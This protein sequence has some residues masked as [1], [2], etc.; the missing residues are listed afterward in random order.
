MLDQIL[1]HFPPH[2]HPLSLVHDPDGLLADEGV[3]A[4][5]AEQGFTLLNEADPVALRHRVQQ[6]RPF[7]LERPLILVTA[8]PLN[9]LPYDLWQPGHPVRLALHTFFPNLS[10]PVV[11]C[12]SPHQRWRLSQVPP[13]QRKLG[14]GATIEAILAGVFGVDLAALRQP[15]GL[16]AWLNAYHPQ[17]DPM[18][19][20]LIER[21]LAHLRSLPVYADWPL[22]DLLTSQDAFTRFVEDQWLTYLQGQTGQPLAE[23]G[24]RYLFYGD[25]G[26]LSFETD[27][28][29]QDTLPQLVRSGA[30]APVSV[31]HPERLPAWMRVGVLAPE[32]DHR[33]RRM[34]ELL[35]VLAE[36]TAPLDELARARWEQWQAV[37]RAWGELATLYYDPDVDVDVG[38]VANLP[39]PGQV[40]N[41]PGQASNLPGQVGNLPGQVSNLP[42]QV[43]NLS[44]SY[45]WWQEKLDQAFLAWLQ[46]RYTPLGGRKLPTPHHL[47]HVLPYIAY[48]WCQQGSRERLALLIMDGMSLADWHLIKSTWRA[49]HPSW[50]FQEQLV[51]AQIPP[52]TAISR[53]ALVSG[54]RSADFSDTLTHNRAE[55][56]QW[57][58]FWTR[59]GLPRSACAYSHL[60]LDRHEPPPELDSARIQAICLVVNVIDDMLHKASL[61]GADMQASLKLWL[62]RKS[63]RLEE[64]IDGLLGRG[65]TIYLTSDHGHTEARGM[66]LRSEGL[67]VETRSK[68]VRVYRDKRTAQNA[69]QGFSKT[70]LWGEDGLLPADTWALMPGGREAFAPFNETVVT[71]GG[72]TLD[73]VVVPLVQVTGPVRPVNDEA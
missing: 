41:L 8:G 28:A 72:P 53:Q 15:A 4:A 57:V 63:L 6:L 18:P 45:G 37:A 43:G 14:R 44:Y 65:F 20:M 67:L 3:L 69:Q 38:Q 33:P 55:P 25:V 30:L 49:R 50:H 66:G 52:I 62:R 47:H 68:R 11:R 13:P 10:Y 12:L 29:L 22:V 7:S 60:A 56:K 71:H 58:A 21:L 64:V 48:Q 1:H 34:A 39:L 54:L 73:E 9:E 40:D 24:E 36:Q 31:E 26:L 42:G 2:T 61:G 35:D 23:A 32:E 17:P 59:E 70:I 46:Q 51:L 16:I 5:L 27:A 19:T